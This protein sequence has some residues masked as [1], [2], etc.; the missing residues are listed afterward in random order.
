MV[1]VLILDG[2]S[3][4]VAHASREIGIFG[5]KRE[6]IVT[7]LDLN[8]CLKRIRYPRALHLHAPISELLSNISAM[9]WPKDSNLF[10][11]LCINI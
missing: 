1:N 2:N 5:E 4:H 3:E 6:S 11:C 9:R 8:E 7:T 10:D